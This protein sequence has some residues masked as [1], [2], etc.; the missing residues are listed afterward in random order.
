MAPAAEKDSQKVDAKV[1]EEKPDKTKSGKNDKKVKEE[2]ELVS[3]LFRFSFMKILATKNTYCSN[4][5][6]HCQIDIIWLLKCIH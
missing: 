5:R 6:W 4:F 2:P 3:G 1:E